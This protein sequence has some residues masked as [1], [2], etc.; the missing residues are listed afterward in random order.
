MIRTGNYEHPEDTLTNATFYIKPNEVLSK[1]EKVHY[2]PT[3]DGFIKLGSFDTV[4]GTLNVFIP[5]E[6]NPI[7]K[8]RIINNSNS[9]HW[10]VIREV[11]FELLSC[12]KKKRRN[13]SH[14]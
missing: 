2:R 14:Q 9:S 3:E 1:A 12:N 11:K 8:V 13:N 6:L 7:E 10:I 5:N 4:M